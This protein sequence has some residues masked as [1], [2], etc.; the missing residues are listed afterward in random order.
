M[1][2]VTVL[3]ELSFVCPLCDCEVEADVELVGEPTK[4]QNCKSVIQV[5]DEGE[6]SIPYGIV[7]FD[8]KTFWFNHRKKLAIAL[9]FIIIGLVFLFL[10]IGGF[11]AVNTERDKAHNRKINRQLEPIEEFLASNP[12]P[13]D[14]DLRRIASELAIIEGPD[15]VNETRIEMAKRLILERWQAKQKQKERESDAE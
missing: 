3:N 15:D 5:P 12:V 14:R 4:C 7:C 11:W 13:S 10:A 1:N 2:I 6:D 9:P 8:V